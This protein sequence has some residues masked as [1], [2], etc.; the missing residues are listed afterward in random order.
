MF[1]FHLVIYEST[2]FSEI[3]LCRYSKAKHVPLY[4]LV[5]LVKNIP[6]T[7]KIAKP[8]SR[9][10]LSPPTWA[11]CIFFKLVLRFRKVTLFLHSSQRLLHS[12]KYVAFAYVTHCIRILVRNAAPIV[13]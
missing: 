1:P 3:S 5:Q 12:T 6:K 11:T 7:C 10:W 8:I 13:L 4:S 9:F 2:P